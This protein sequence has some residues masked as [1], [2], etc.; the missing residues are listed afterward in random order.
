MPVIIKKV[1]S[2]QLSV[3]KGTGNRYVDC[4]Q[5]CKG[6]RNPKEIP[7]VVRAAMELKRWAP[8]AGAV[9]ATKDA[10]DEFWDALSA[11]GLEK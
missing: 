3:A 4:Y 1:N 6:I 5:A 9:G 2:D 7:G 8:D 11:L 10:F